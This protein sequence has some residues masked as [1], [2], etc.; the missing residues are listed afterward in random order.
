M[1]TEDAAVQSQIAMASGAV[2]RVFDWDRAARRIKE[3][4][5]KV[6]G[7]GLQ[8][9]WEWTGGDIY[10]DGVPIPSWD[11]YTYLSSPWAI[12]EL[13]LDGVVEDCF[14]ARDPENNPQGWNSSTY[15]PN[16]ALEIL[17]AE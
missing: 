16:S 10:R 8:Q 12:P 11:T 4:G 6:A 14:I 13:S 9:D 15:W 2:G 7:A 3:S 17:T 1:R 5:A